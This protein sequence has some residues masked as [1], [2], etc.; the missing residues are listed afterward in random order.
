MG[1]PSLDD[2][3]AVKPSGLYGEKDHENKGFGG[4][5]PG[6]LGPLADLARVPID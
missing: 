6:A 2:I 5:N 4:I 1:I 3:M